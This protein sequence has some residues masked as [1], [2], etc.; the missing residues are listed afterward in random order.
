M[1]IKKRGV[2]SYLYIFHMFPRNCSF[3]R[4]P[5]EA[6]L[7]FVFTT[8]THHTTPHHTT[9]HHTTPHHITSHHTPHVLFNTGGGRKGGWRRVRAVG[10]VK[11]ELE[12][13]C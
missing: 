10:F 12:H 6:V 3:F 8:T 13:R 11:G 9:P 4:N 5:L 2:L 1:T 7:C